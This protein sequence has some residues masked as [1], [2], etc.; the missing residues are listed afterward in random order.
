MKFQVILWPFIVLISLNACRQDASQRKIRLSDTPRTV[1]RNEDQL[2]TTIH[3]E[4]SQQR[5]I[6]VMFFKNRT[7]DQNLEWLQKGLAEMFIRAL[8]QSHHLSVLG[9]D[10]LIEILER[11]DQDVNQKVDMDMAAVV[12]KE[13]NVEVLL[14]GNIYRHGES[15]Q[16]NVQLVEP[17]EGLVLREES[18]EGTGME[19]ILTM[20]DHISQKIQQ[21][22]QFPMDGE[23]T[24]RGVAEL[25]TNSMEAWQQYTLAEEL[26][27]QVR[28]QE[29]IPHYKKAIG[30]DSAFVS[31]YLKLL[32]CVAG[33]GDNETAFALYQMAEK[34][35]DNATR[36]EKYQ[37]ELTRA[38]F[39]ADIEHLLN[40]QIDWIKKNPTDVRAHNDLANLYFGLRNY[41]KAI[42]Y[43]EKTYKLDPKHKLTMNQL[44]Y[45]YALTG[46][47]DQAEE[48]LNE[49]RKTV[50]DEPNPYDS[51]GDIYLFQGEYKKAARYFR[52][53]LEKT[54]EFTPAYDHLAN[55]AVE[56]G[57]YKKAIAY[58][59]QSMNHKLQ[60]A[61]KSKT[62]CD[63]AG[64]YQRIGN[65]QKSLS[66]YRDALEEYP[67]QY[68]PALEIA[69]IYK[70]QGDT[71]RAI[72]IFKNQY[73]QIRTALTTDRKK[74]DHFP[75]LAIISIWHRI[76]PEQSLRLID[77]TL[78]VIDNPFEMLRAKFLKMLL[79]IQLGR[80]DEIDTELQEKFETQFLAVMQNVKNI[81]YSHM[82]RLFHI[83]NDMLAEMPLIGIATYQHLIESSEKCDLNFYETGFRG[84]LADLY[85]RTGNHSGASEQVRTAGMPL[86]S[87]WFVI[88]PFENRDGFNRRFPPEKEFDI[89]RTYQ[90]NRRLIRW[91]RLDDGY[92]DGYIDL[93]N[94]FIKSEWS[95]A[96][97][98]IHIESPEEK[99][100]Q[101]RTGSD[102]GIKIWLNG[103]EV[104]RLNRI[105][106]AIIDDQITPVIL[107]P[108]NNQVLIKICNRYR[109]WGFYFRVTDDKGK[110]IQAIRFISAN[111]VHQKIS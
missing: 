1:I 69:E 48:I 95:V 111:D 44:G 13:A 60:G 101:F 97:G 37:L 24:F 59:E 35:K 65:T 108:G 9:T 46:D 51:L 74:R 18:V 4:P 72:D 34:L 26:C 12:A 36:K 40:L 80:T 2:T 45:C 33:Q 75:L 58:F 11:M 66:I 85:M 110:G 87:L 107:Q 52:M 20:V 76:E 91:K 82:W 89:D 68:N 86:D 3:L 21:D 81:G 50:P 17:Y 27:N 8:S 41:D 71:S 88:G 63:I 109:N 103:E 53:A 31:P 56:S 19:T 22:L 14:R 43:Y 25:S 99:E 39:N 61:P 93:K 49:Y 90:Q 42:E 30:L 79:L 16:L 102:E 96:Y 29:A 32:Q 10:R 77:S 104:W 84:L 54:E 28:I 47:Y 73:H 106:D 64:L 23:N 70:T 38:G 62:L 7:G 100:V 15:L 67:F 78:A 6:A 57:D 55:A 105:Q 5:S 92:Y 98:V 83:L 94:Q